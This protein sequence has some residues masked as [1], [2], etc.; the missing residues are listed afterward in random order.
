[1]KINAI[2]A[3]ELADDLAKMVPS[4]AVYVFVAF[5]AVMM[6]KMMTMPV[7]LTRS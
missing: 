3:L 4:G 1:M 7:V 6:Q 2:S 5:K